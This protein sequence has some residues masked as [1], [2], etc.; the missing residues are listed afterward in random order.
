M[1]FALDPH[2]PEAPFPAV[3]QALREP[4]G[5][6][7]VGGDL[8]PSRLVRAYRQGIF[9]WYSIGQPPLWWS[10]DPRTV[11][12]PEDL[13]ISRSLRK[14]LRRGMLTTSVDRDFA[15]VIEGCADPRKGEADTWITP[16]MRRAYLRLHEL[17]IAHSVETW[18]QGR[19]VGGLYGLA[20]GAVFF[21]ESMFS[22]Y[23]DASKVA[24]VALVER[25]RRFDMRLIDCQMRSDHLI[26]LGAMEIPRARFVR[27]LAV[28]RDIPCGPEVWADG[29]GVPCA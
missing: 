20:I 10:P 14:T 19:L 3:H 11:L 2:D 15:G 23:S 21:G 6:L 7:A 29:T 9:P 5:L 12:V 8:S 27:M 1:L 28:L 22:R 17:G 24:L 18:A 13:K 4:D 16:E 25:M 26:R